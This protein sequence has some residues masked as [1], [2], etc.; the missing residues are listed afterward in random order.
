MRLRPLAFALAALVPIPGHASDLRRDGAAFEF[1][2]ELKAGAI[3]EECLR[4]PKAASRE[5]EWQSTVPVDFNIHFHRG[6]DVSYPVRLSG[7]DKGR[8]RFTAGGDEDYCWMWTAKTPATVTG[9][10]GPQR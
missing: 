5:F 7:K 6:D 9:R 4:L 1:R 8:G 10:L 3:A 2:H